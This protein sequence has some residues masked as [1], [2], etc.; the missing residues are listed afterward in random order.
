MLKGENYHIKARN[1][2]GK[3]LN[4]HVDNYAIV[5]GSFVS[6]F[7][8]RENVWKRFHS[9]NCEIYNEVEE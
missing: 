9:S 8:K 4:F 6:F 5:D 2:T 7:D 3:V 1:L